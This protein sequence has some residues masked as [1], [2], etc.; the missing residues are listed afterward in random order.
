M[1]VL[2]T[3]AGGFVGINIVYHL[4]KEGYDVFGLDVEPL[5]SS[6]LDYLGEYR[7][8]FELITADVTNLSE[9]EEKFH[10]KD[11]HRIVHAAALTSP[12]LSELDRFTAL[13]QVNLLGTSNMLEF[14]RSLSNLDSFLY[15]SSASVYG[16]TR[17]DTLI[18]ETFPLKGKGAYSI[19]KEASEHLTHRYRNLYDIDTSVVRLGWVYGPME[20]KTGS[21]QN[22]S[23]IYQIFDL[24]DKG[25]DITINNTEAVRDWVH[26]MDVARAIVKVLDKPNRRFNTYNI[27]SGEPYSISRIFELIRRN[28]PDLRYEKVEDGSTEIQVNTDNRR[29]ALDITRL[30]DDVAYSPKYGIE[31]GLYSY[32]KWFE[33]WRE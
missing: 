9:I 22:M 17:E 1:N 26:A 19:T 33:Q 14:S 21:R 16:N 10:A 7:D 30:R 5:E 15:V 6:E 25:V 20:R 32:G 4:L 11:I 23:L 31:D 24:M 29:G 27:S 3:G 8:N 13:S 2:V 18:D 12:G 28:F